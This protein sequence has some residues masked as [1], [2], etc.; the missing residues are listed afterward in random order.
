V[1]RRQPD[2]RSTFASAAV[3][4]RVIELL[5]ID[6]STKTGTYDED[7]VAPAAMSKRTVRDRARRAV[8]TV[9]VK[10]KQVGAAARARWTRRSS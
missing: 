5:T 3:T 4:D 2:G 6:A 10:T 7:A 8:S 9:T 1:R